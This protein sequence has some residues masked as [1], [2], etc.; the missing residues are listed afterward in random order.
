MYREINTKHFYR[1][2][3][4]I[5]IANAAN[6]K[7]SKNGRK[8]K[9]GNVKIV[10]IDEKNIVHR[11]RNDLIF[12]HDEALEKEQVDLN[13]E[14]KDGG[15]EEPELHDSFLVFIKYVNFQKKQLEQKCEMIIPLDDAMNVDEILERALPAD[16]LKS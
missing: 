16:K 3:S 11:L 7:A 8:G 10:E 14:L 4:P 6:Q 15:A 5:D 12:N 9:S 13:Q 2:Y 1:F